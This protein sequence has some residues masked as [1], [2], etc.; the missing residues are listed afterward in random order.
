VSDDDLADLAGEGL[1]VVPELLRLVFDSHMKEIF[2]TMK[3]H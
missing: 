3:R 2:N 1:D